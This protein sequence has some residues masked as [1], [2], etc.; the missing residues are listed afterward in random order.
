M[1]IRK[2]RKSDIDALIS[3]FIR[4]Y[5]KEPWNEN[6]SIKRAK[7]FFKDHYS[8]SIGFVAV[9]DEILGF[10]ILIKEIN[11][12]CDR[13]MVKDVVIDS[14]YH[15]EGIGKELMKYAEAYCTEQGIK[16]IWLL[17]STD[18]AAYKFYKKVGYTHEKETAMFYKVI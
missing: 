16:E 7:E 17:T 9:D 6:W 8:N 1:E 2:W 4:E 15:G 5:A 18:S 13:M 12:S 3:I 14:Q 11:W 10:I